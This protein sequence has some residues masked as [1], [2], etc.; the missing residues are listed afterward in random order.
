MVDEVNGERQDAEACGEK[1]KFMGAVVIGSDHAGFLLKQ[2]L[3]M[4]LREGKWQVLDIGRS[5]KWESI[6]ACKDFPWPVSPLSNPQS[7]TP[8]IVPAPFFFVSYFS[9]LNKSP[10]PLSGFRAR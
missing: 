2:D 6:I 4:F 5:S 9:G 8:W 1:E 7:M 3:V 10:K